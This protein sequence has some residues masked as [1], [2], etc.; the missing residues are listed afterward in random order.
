MNELQK[1]F[2]R[3]AYEGKKFPQE[4]LE[5]IIA[6]KEEAIPYLRNAVEKAM[7]ERY[8]LEEGYQLHFYAIYLLGEFKDRDFFP[9]LIE[10]ATLPGDELDYL[11]G[12]VV[13]AGLKDILYN[14]YNGD[15]ELLKKTALNSNVDEYVRSGLLDVMGQLYFDGSLDEEE[16]KAF[17]K[18]GVYSG[19]EYSYFYNGLGNAICQCHFVDMLSELR[20]MLDNDLMDEMFFGKYDSCVDNMFEYREYDDKFCISPINTINMLKHWA[21]FQDESSKEDEEKRMKEFK[22]YLTM[23]SRKSS[24]PKVGRNDPCPCG[25]GKKYKFCCMKK[26]KSPLDAIES[27]LERE[28]VMQ[29]YPYTGEERQEGRIYLEDYFDSESI[30]IDKM[31]YLGLINRPG[32]IWLRNEEEEEKRCQRYLSLAFEMFIKKAEKENIQNF[33]EYDQRFS[34]HYLCEEWMGELL[35]LSKKEGNDEL[36]KRVD[37]YFQQMRK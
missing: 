5:I 20:Y 3:V 12:D 8:E 1:A 25:S 29:G 37:K 18:Q 9:K 26:P 4:A 32:Y 30:E 33:E 6:N 28:R 22:K 21:M 15:M 24:N 10:F 36:Y 34:I 31:L 27:A 17:I 35:R 14:T 7:E 23:E 19:E 11:I 16:W 13:T 2:E